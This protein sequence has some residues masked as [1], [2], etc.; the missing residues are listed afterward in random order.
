MK[1]SSS[2]LQLGSILLLITLVTLFFVSIIGIAYSVPHK[3]KTYKMI[4]DKCY[5]VRS[6]GAKF[7]REE[8]VLTN[9]D[10][11]K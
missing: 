10:N 1:E 3:D 8:Y 11:C 6:I 5:E 2:D 4:D 9:L 7:H